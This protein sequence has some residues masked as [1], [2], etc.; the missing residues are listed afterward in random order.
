MHRGLPGRAARA[1]DKGQKP[2][3]L[4]GSL[5]LLPRLECSGMT[6]V[7][8][9]S[10]SWVQ[11]SI[12]LCTAHGLFGGSRFLH[13]NLAVR[14]RARWLTSVIPALWEAEMGES[15]EPK[16]S[17]AAWATWKNPIST[18]N[19]K[20]SQ[21]WW[22]TPVVP[23]TQ[24]AGVRVNCAWEVEAP[25]ISLSLITTLQRSFKIPIK[26]NNKPIKGQAQWLTSVIPALWEAEVGRSPEEFETSL[27]NMVKLRVH[28]KNYKN[29]L[30]MVNFTLLPRLE[31]SDTI[32]AHCKLC[33]LGSRHCFFP[34]RGCSNKGPSQKQRAALTTQENAAILTLDFPASRTGLR[35]APKHWPAE[36]ERSGLSKPGLPGDPKHPG[37][38]KNSTEPHDNAEGGYEEERKEEHADLEV[39]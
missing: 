37:T 23:A 15:L 31:C 39:L 19:T 8:A 36:E 24:E 6:S 13:T 29:Y 16:S 30:G 33:P 26:K 25:T 9:T 2:F 34:S 35:W 12:N 17:R 27:G 1:G 32:S 14:G 22:C 38:H 3:G 20:I 4:A 7:P 21:V 10:A 11:I 18:K 28:K 5:A